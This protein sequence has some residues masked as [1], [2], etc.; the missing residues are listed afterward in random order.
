MK[1]RF[2]YG[3]LLLSTLLLFE[4][5]QN[6]ANNQGNTTTDKN[7]QVADSAAIMQTA[8]PDPN[9]PMMKF[10]EAQFDF[11]SIKE[12]EVVK[13]TFSFTNTGKSPLTIQHAQAS[14]GCTVPVWPKEPIAPG[15]KGDIK[16]EF[17]SAGKAGP[18]TKTIT[19]QANTQPSETVIQ[20]VGTVESTPAD[21]LT[22]KK[23][24]HKH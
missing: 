3:G 11:G 12:G 23:N 13:H 8:E 16:V 20:L 7:T 2:F 15:Q 22:G 18:Q 19:I 4:A 1:N 10:E 17:N 9:A 24:P 14:C 21:T 5:C 6:Q